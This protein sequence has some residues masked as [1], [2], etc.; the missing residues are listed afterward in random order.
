MHPRGL[1]LAAP[2][3]INLHLEV[4]HRRPDGFHALETVFQTIGWADAVEVALAPGSGIA[5]TQDGP[6]AGPAIPSDARNLAWRA[7]ALFSARW[8]VPGQ[9]RI[10]LHK[11][12]PAGA[13]LGGGSSD[14]AAVLRALARLVPADPEGLAAIASS[15]GS[16]VPFF[17]LGGTAH[18]T[19]RGE[20]LTALPDVAPRPV[21]L[22]LPPA[23]CPTPQIYAALTDAER[24]PRAAR[25]ADWWR[26]ALAQ[27]TWSP[28]PN[29][30]AGPAR[31]AEP[32]VE[33]LL[34]SLEEQGVPHLLCG[35]GAACVAFAPC[36]APVGTQVV[37]T[38]LRPRAALDALGEGAAP[39]ETTTGAVWPSA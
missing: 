10:H 3:K 16:D 26:R 9:V 38:H 24:G 7:A 19:G 25:G 18:A 27:P 39:P 13:G 30:L 1:L 34:A 36:R 6:A 5:L 12:I 22:L 28:E 17:L 35:S 29:R 37:P 15:I 4:L 14:A 2:A 33:R 23:A 20:I 32:L 11:R 21:W 31:R 8:P